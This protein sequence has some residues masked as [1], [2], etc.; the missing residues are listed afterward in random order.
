M[1]KITEL[2]GHMSRVLYMAM[3]PDGCSL[4]SGAGDETLRFWKIHDNK[5]T[6]NDSMDFKMMNSF[7]LR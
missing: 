7:Q 2:N 5:I 3:S 1:Y 6:N 4:V